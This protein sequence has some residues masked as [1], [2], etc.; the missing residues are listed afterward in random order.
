[1]LTRGVDSSCCQG[2]ACWNLKW[3]SLLFKYDF[4][5]VRPLQ[6]SW[7]A[8]LSFVRHRKGRRIPE[9]T[10][11]AQTT[12]RSK[13][14]MRCVVASGQTCIVSN[15]KNKHINTRMHTCTV[16]MHSARMSSSVT[17]SSSGQSYCRWIGLTDFWSIE[18][19][20]AHDVHTTC[21]DDVVWLL[22]VLRC[23]YNELVKQHHGSGGE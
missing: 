3:P 17:F 20:S 2:S 21:G 14:Q 23:A 22:Q 13:R 5:I 10:T 9:G 15:H 4:T 11:L 18:D 8:L 7:C 1:M 16:P 19:Y 6:T 12:L